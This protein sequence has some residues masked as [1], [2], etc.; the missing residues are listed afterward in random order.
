MI[1]TH[2]F[3]C[4]A[5]EVNFLL[6][7]AATASTPSL[8]ITE[9]G[10]EWSIKSSTTLKTVELKFKVTNAE[11]ITFLFCLGL[12]YHLYL[13]LGEKFDETTPDGRQVSSLAT[14]DGGKLTIKQ[15]ND[16]SEYSVFNN[17]LTNKRTVL[18][19]LSKG[20]NIGTIHLKESTQYTLEQYIQQTKGQP[21]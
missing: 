8:D 11:N 15:V 20:N 2:Q 9:S 1:F 13:Q 16:Q 12:K 14:F 6:R 7:K 19:Q 3:P 21:N 10:G 18:R 5:L 4:Q 17:Y